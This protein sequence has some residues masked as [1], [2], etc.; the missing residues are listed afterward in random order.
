MVTPFINTV[1]FKFRL[2]SNWC[3]KPVKPIS[4]KEQAEIDEKHAKTLATYVE[5]LSKAKEMENDDLYLKIQN[6]MNEYLKV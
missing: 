4:Q 3:Y 5:L 6:E 2:Q 1:L